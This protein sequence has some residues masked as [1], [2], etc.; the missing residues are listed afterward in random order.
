M[1]ESGV[2]EQLVGWDS[3]SRLTPDLNTE[4][5]GQNY[6][7]SYAT[8]G[9]ANNGKLARHLKQRFANGGELF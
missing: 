1:R 6:C 9:G 8:Y 2:T 3:Q 4:K 5:P 7:Q